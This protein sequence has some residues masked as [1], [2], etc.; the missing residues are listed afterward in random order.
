MM[1]ASVVVLSRMSKRC[2]VYAPANCRTVGCKIAKTEKIKRPTRDSNAQSSEPKSDALAIRPMG[3]RFVENWHMRQ[4][5]RKNNLAT[6]QP[7]DNLSGPELWEWFT[8]LALPLSLFPFSL[9]RLFPTFFSH[10]PYSTSLAVLNNE[11]EDFMMIVP[12][13]PSAHPLPRLITSLAQQ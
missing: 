1:G 2:Q 12:L 5:L 9:L 10:R 4:R 11:C 6:V 13:K 8:T 3:L 7:C